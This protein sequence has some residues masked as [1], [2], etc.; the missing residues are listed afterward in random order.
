MYGGCWWQR[1]DQGRSRNIGEQ[2][3]EKG[4]ETREREK[5]FIQTI[6]VRMMK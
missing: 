2:R 6:L 5:E 3:K 1:E 4:K